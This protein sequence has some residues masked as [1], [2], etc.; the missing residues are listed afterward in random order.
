MGASAMPFTEQI[1]DPDGRAM[2]IEFAAAPTEEMYEFLKDYIELR[3]KA[4]RRKAS[5][6]TPAP[7]RVPAEGAANP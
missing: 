2:R 6:P 4:L 7:T 1:L 5:V 3:L